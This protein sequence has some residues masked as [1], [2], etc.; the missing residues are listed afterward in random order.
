[1]SQP[2]WTSLHYRSLAI[3]LCLKQLRE[4]DTCILALQQQSYDRQLLLNLDSRVQIA[5]ERTTKAERHA[6]ITESLSLNQEEELLGDRFSIFNTCN[7]NFITERKSLFREQACLF[8]GRDRNG[9]ALGRM[10][11]LN[12]LLTGGLLTSLPCHHPHSPSEISSP[13]LD[14]F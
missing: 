4:V 2:Q 13:I 1:M 11:L 10:Q 14:Y 8:E 3:E 5:Q 6:R 7:S 12:T 9:Y